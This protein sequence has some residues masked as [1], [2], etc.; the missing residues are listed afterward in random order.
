MSDFNRLKMKEKDSIDSFV[1]R[2]GKITSKS[3]ALGEII[4]ETKLVKKLLDC[5]PRKK[6][7]L[8]VAAL[9]QILD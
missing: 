4:E 5:L 8:M 6:F 2:I 3:A 9:E 1:G 7:I